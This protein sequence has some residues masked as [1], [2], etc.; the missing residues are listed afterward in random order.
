MIRY[1]H[2]SFLAFVLLCCN[3]AIEEHYSVEEYE[4]NKLI[5]ENYETVFEIGESYHELIDI[6]SDSNFYFVDASSKKLLKFDFDGNLIAMIGEEGRGPNQFSEHVALEGVINDST[7]Y[8]IEIG[9]YRVFEYDLDLNY[10]KETAVE[11][12]ILQMI[13][14]KPDSIFIAFTSTSTMGTN[15]FFGLGFVDSDFKEYSSTKYPVNMQNYFYELGFE[16]A[17]MG[18]G[19][20][21]FCYSAIN[22]C[23]IESFNQGGE[24]AY[25]KIKGL[26]EKAES[27]K[28]QIKKIPKHLLIRDI[29][30]DKISGYIYV[31]EGSAEMNNQYEGSNTIHVFNE[32]GKYMKSY[33]LPF[34]V[35]QVHIFQKTLFLLKKNSMKEVIVKINL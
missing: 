7:L 17:D 29:F 30:Y 34:N 13:V 35:E 8:V 27:E 31:L 2:I 6:D 32:S 20:Y 10:K 1:I 15:T 21:L 14:L 19:N 16:I 28:D 18:N 9:G 3:D 4:I 5:L 23:K 11:D 12:L 22:K 26:D 33:L 24:K 25:F